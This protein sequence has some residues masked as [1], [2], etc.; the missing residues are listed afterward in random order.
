MN[1]SIPTSDAKDS[2]PVIEAEVTVEN[3]TEDKPPVGAAKAAA[4]SVT[5]ALKD[6]W[7]NACED[8]KKAAEATLPK[9]KQVAAKAAYGA[10]YVTG[11]GASFGVTLVKEILP[12]AVKTGFKK[13]CDQGKEDAEK[14]AQPD[15]VEIPPSVAGQP[16]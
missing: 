11:Y 15:P 12:E 3:V 7:Q 8:A 10:S 13:G 14:V 6:G 9:V 1:D 2:A 4:S 16:A 5:Q